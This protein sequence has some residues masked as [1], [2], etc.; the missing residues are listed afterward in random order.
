[1]AQPPDKVDPLLG[2]TLGESEIVELLGRGGMGAVYKAKQPALGRFVAI[3]VL[4][5]S[6]ASDAS[7]IERFQRE[8][9][10]AAAVSH[11]NI[12]QVLTVGQDKGYQFIAMEFVE[13]ENLAEI[14][15]RDGRCRADR[16]G[17]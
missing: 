3:K 16:N 7:F 5:C 17:C 10:D 4:P 2:Q 8:A 15:K 11:P 14:L 12:I 1:M 6:L 9:R 13:G